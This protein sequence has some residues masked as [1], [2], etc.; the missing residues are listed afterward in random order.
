MAP[1]GINMTS[2][3]TIV[4]ILDNTQSRTFAHNH[5]ICLCMFV[6][7]NEA[8][9]YH[10]TGHKSHNLPSTILSR[11]HHPPAS[12]NS[13]RM[14]LS[15]ACV[16]LSLVT[17]V[18]LAISGLIVGNVIAQQ[19][20][21]LPD[22]KSN[23]SSVIP[24]TTTTTSS[25]SASSNNNYAAS[26]SLLTAGNNNNERSGY[27]HYPRDKLFSFSDSLY[28]GYGSEALKNL[29]KPSPAYYNYNK[30]VS[31]PR[32]QNDAKSHKSRSLEHT[33]LGLVLQSPLQSVHDA[34]EQL[35]HRK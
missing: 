2:G 21:H 30:N 1:K 20:G 6:M 8:R 14:Y 35:L 12:P 15:S 3:S 5:K 28:S 23:A 25:A 33:G 13:H 32:L 11:L 24:T 18:S 17:V 26:I 27:L 19:S 16:S 31:L 29:E 7:P 4:A 22:D 9:R 34:C 10:T